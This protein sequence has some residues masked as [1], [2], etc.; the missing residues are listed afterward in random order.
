MSGHLLLKVYIWMK[1]LSYKYHSSLQQLLMVTGTFALFAFVPFFCAYFIYFAHVQYLLRALRIHLAVCGCM[2][3]SLA[4]PF[5][6]WLNSIRSLP[7]RSALVW[8]MWSS[9]ATNCSHLSLGIS[10]LTSHFDAKCSWVCIINVRASLH[11]LCDPTFIR[12]TWK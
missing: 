9:I 8:C 11:S 12:K 5:Y 2:A 3:H 7:W 1:Y 10:G 6:W 4:I